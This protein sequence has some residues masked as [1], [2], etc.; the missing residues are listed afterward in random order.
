MTEAE[1]IAELLKTQEMLVKRLQHLAEVADMHV[2]KIG[3]GEYLH[4]V[5]SGFEYI[6]HEA[7]RGALNGN[8]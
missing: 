5:R 4:E 3:N 1:Q 6:A 7:R 8:H 2:R